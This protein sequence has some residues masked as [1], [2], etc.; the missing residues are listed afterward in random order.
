MQIRRVVVEEAA[1]QKRGKRWSCGSA[2]QPSSCCCSSS[3][4]CCC[5]SSRGGRVP[6]A[7]NDNSKET[8]VF[9]SEFTRGL[10]KGE[11]PKVLGEFDGLRGGLEVCS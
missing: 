1:G 4:C 3:S 8:G 2:C 5:S 7:P 6:Q 11:L 10:T 9:L